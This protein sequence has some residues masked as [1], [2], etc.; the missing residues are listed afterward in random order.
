MSLDTATSRTDFG[1]A[2]LED[3][4]V[5]QD[6]TAA[7]LERRVAARWGDAVIAAFVVVGGRAGDWGEAIGLY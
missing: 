5:T 2:D 7:R 4:V 1:A 6:V 3:A